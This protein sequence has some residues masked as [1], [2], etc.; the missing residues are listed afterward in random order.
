M[1][2]LRPEYK[3]NT[4]HRFNFVGRTRFPRK[5]YSTTSQNLTVKYL[6]S[7]ST[8]DIDGT[9][10]SVRDAFT[11]DVIVPFG[12]GSIVSCDSNGNYF[13]LWLSSFQPE[14]DYR[15]LFQVVSGSN[16][17]DELDMIFDD[18]WEFKVKR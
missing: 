10:Y 12:T 1:K 15:I 5:I 2:G 6:P 8:T 9:Y 4:K 11:E 3:E 16:T 17:T 14:R 7:G 13:N 18:S